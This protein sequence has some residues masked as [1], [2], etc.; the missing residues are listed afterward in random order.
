MNEVRMDEC[1][2]RLQPLVDQYKN[3]DLRFDRNNLIMSWRQKISFKKGFFA[4]IEVLADT[5]R[6][7]KKTLNTFYSQSLNFNMI[8][9]K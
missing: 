6:C 3:P 9:M 8:I 2:A 7:F 4:L 5:K 1:A